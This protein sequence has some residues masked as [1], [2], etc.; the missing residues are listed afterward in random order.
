MATK[1]QYPARFEENEDGRFS[2]FFPDLKGCKTSGND[3]REALRNAK[4]ALSV[5]LEEH[6]ERKGNLPPVSDLKG[7]D[8][9]WIRPDP[10]VEVPILLRRFREE[11]RITQEEVAKRLGVFYTSYKRLERPGT[12]ITIKTLNKVAAVLGYGLE[13]SFRK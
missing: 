11:A 2:V 9:H 7:E 6:F 8:I 10:D 1:I 13:I 3:L 12:N 5:W 4:K